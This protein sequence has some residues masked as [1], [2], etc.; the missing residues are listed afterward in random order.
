MIQAWMR[1]VLLI[2]SVYNTAWAIFLFWSPDSYIKWMTNGDQSSND[3]VFYQA[4]GILIVGFMM[5]LGFLKPLR[6]KW[7][8]LL[9][10]LAKLIGGIAVYFVIMNGVFTKKFMFHLLMNDL[11]WLIPLLSIVIATFKPKN[12]R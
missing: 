5:F 4:I 1:G 3:W 9:S 12:S 6:F 11:V 7:L 2:A 10:F 8:I